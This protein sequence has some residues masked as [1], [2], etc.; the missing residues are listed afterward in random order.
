MPARTF[1]T[2]I[3]DLSVKANRQYVDLP[4]QAGVTI[5]AAKCSG[6]WSTV[7]LKV[8]I[9]GVGV[10]FDFDSPKGIS[11]GGGTA[12]IAKDESL[13]IATIVIAMDPT[14]AAEAAGT[15]CIVTVGIEEPSV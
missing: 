1:E 13:G 10:L 4:A 6:T 14:A 5:T 15:T 2:F 11:A 12:F 9:P 3:L 7:A 8:Q